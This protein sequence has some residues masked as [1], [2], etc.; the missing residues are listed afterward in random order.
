MRQKS[1][2]A[3]PRVDPAPVPPVDE[4]ELRAAQAAVGVLLLGAFVFRMPELV[5]VV[6][7]VVGAGRAAR[8]ARQPVPRGV[9]GRRRAAA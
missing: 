7:V 1:P 8:P 3:S 9:P 6:T 5:Y 2:I 4:R